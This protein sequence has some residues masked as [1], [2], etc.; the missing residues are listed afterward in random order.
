VVG[1]VAALF[2]PK[3]YCKYGCPSGALLEFVRARGVNDKF[4]RRDWVAGLLLLA[5][6]AMHWQHAAL[7]QL[8]LGPAV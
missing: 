3:A 8:T 7:C 5:G 4:G 6:W 2:V 1:L